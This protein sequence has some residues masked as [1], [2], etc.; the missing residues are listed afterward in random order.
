M[1]LRTLRG[2]STHGGGFL[3]SFGM[4]MFKS[5]HSEH[6]EVSIEILAKI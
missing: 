1:L 3:T 2:I 6:S 4:T 5:Y